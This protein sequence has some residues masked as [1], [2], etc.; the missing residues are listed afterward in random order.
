MR[1]EHLKRSKTSR[2][3]ISVSTTKEKSKFMKDHN[4][5]PTAIFNE[6]VDEIIKSIEND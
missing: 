2:V 1:I 4:L 6:K 5:S 3:V